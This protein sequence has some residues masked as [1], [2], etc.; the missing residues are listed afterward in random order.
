VYLTS[1]VTINGRRVAAN[2]SILYMTHIPR[3][4]RGRMP[5]FSLTDHQRCA[6][7]VGWYQTVCNDCTE[8]F[9]EIRDRVVLGRVRSL[10]VLDKAYAVD[11]LESKFV[12]VDSIVMKMFLVPHFTDRDKEIA[13][14]M[15]ELT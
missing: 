5:Q 14:P 3:V 15:R 8:L 2:D 9:A 13:I 1:G 7:L 12:H 11:Q 4:H 10:V 6:D